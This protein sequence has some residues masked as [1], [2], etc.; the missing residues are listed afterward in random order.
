MGA[1]AVRVQHE[2]RGEQ[3]DQAGNLNAAFDVIILPDISKDVI[4]DGKPRP[5]DGGMKYFEEMPPEY[6][7]GIGKEG[8]KALKDFVE[9]GGTLITFSSAGDLIADEFN[10]P[11]M[12]GVARAQDL[13]VPGSIV[14]MNLDMTSPISYGMPAEIAAFVSEPITYR[15]SNPAPDIK[16][17]ILASYPTDVEDILL[18]GYIRGGEALSRQASAVEFGVGKGQ[19]VM[20]GFGVQHRAQ[21]EG[22]FKMLFNAIQQAGYLAPGEKPVAGQ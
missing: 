3:N 10:L 11:V 21:T 8:V 7:G 12:N 14:R 20:F 15:T 19:I 22:T 9:K 2:K 6:Q 18:S 5:R 16:R 17:S 4:V 1:G 13:N